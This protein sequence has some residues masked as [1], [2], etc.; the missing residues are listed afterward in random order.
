MNSAPGSTPAYS[1][2]SRAPG[3]IVQIVRTVSPPPS[4][5]IFSPSANVGVAIS[6]QVSP[7]SVER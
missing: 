5:S 3:W 1:S 2:P 4:A 6:C 7:Q